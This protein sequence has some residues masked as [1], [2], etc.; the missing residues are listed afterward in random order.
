MNLVSIASGGQNET[1]QLLIIINFIQDIMIK[2][3]RAIRFQFDRAGQIINLTQTKFSR[4][5]CKLLN[6][7][8]NF[9]PTQ[10]KINKKELHNW[11]NPVDVSN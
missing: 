5:T 2:L 8:L 10:N 7:N 3:Q 11:T 4:E 1:I 9:V 6:K